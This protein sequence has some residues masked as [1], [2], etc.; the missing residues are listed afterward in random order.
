MKSTKKTLLAV[1]LTFG[2]S[3]GIAVAQ[4]GTSQ[5]T[6]AQQPTM[7]GQQG[8]MGQGMGQGMGMGMGHKGMG[9]HMMM[10]QQ[11]Q[12]MMMNGGMGQGCMRMTA[13]MSPEQRQQFFDATHDLR[14]Q[15]HD[16]RFD[17]MEARRNP[18]TTQGQLMEMEQKMA[19]IRQ[20]VMTKA[21]SIQQ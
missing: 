5:D 12:G 19:E 11:G 8:M 13:N 10:G 9:R 15:M 1:L 6:T 14:K 18:A 16:L 4:S 21:Q 3:S 2:L 17:Y 20:Q 7:M